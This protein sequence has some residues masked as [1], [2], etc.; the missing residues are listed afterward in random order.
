MK[1]SWENV[2]WNENNFVP[3]HRQSETMGVDKAFF[4]RLKHIVYHYLNPQKYGENG[5]YG[6]SCQ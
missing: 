3:L 1:K 5:S 2:W 6:I 4:L